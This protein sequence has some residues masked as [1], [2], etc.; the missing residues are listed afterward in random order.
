[1]K[2]SM[3]QQYHPVFDTPRSVWVFDLDNTLYHAECNLF[4]QI[5]KKIGSYVQN[6]L[7]LSPTDARTVQKRYLVDHGTTLNGL[8][9]NHKVDPHHYLDSVHDIDFSPIKPD[10]VLREALTDFDGRK[11]VFTN[12]DRPYAEKVLERLGVKDMFE[13]IFGILESDLKPKPVPEVYDK[14]IKQYDFD[15]NDAVMFEDMARNLKPAHDRGMA[16]VWI[17]TGSTWGEIDH[18]PAIIHAETDSLSKWL[19]DFPSK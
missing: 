7:G 4:S 17:N 1:M 16:T 12:A 9:A 5:D 15:P 10:P 8:I 3:P 18:D 6:L 19:A 13:S 11:I 2:N 14:F